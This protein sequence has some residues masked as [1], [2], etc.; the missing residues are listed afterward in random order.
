MSDK[1]GGHDDDREDTFLGGEMGGFSVEGH[2]FLDGFDKEKD[3]RSGFL[4]FGY[5]YPNHQYFELKLPHDDTQLGH[6]S[7]LGDS[8]EN[9]DPFLEL[10]E[11]LEAPTP[12]HVSQNGTYHPAVVS[13][14][15]EVGGVVVEK[16]EEENNKE[17]LVQ[18][19]PSPP[20]PPQEVHNHLRLSYTSDLK[21]RLRWTQDLHSCFVNAVKELGGPQISP[22]AIIEI[23]LRPVWCSNEKYRQGRRSVREFNEPLR[24]GISAAQGSE[25]PSS[26]MN[27]PPSQAKNSKHYTCLIDFVASTFGMLH[28]QLGLWL[29]AADQN[30]NQQATP[31]LVD[32]A[33]QTIHRYLHAQ[34]SYLSIAI[35]NACKFVSNQC[36]EGAALENGNYY[37]HGF[38]GSRS[39]NTALL[40]PYFY[41][42]QLNA[43]YACNSME[44]VNAGI[45]VEM[46]WSSFQ[47]PTT[48]QSGTENSSLPVGH[49]AGSCLEGSKT[50]PVQ[51]SEED[52]ASYEDPVD[53][54]LN[55]DDTC[56]NIL[57]IDYGRF[58][59]DGGVGTSK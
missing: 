39:G 6:L 58:D 35:N 57:A 50:L 43:S 56:T 42:N 40:M 38:T 32:F 9:D 36:V 14:N 3:G 46:P 26:S 53:D 17:G 29:S 22:D 31:M 33:Q 12:H 2:H 37:G 19:P 45:S 54:Y 48:V 59:L 24:N 20:R 27:L 11:T 4:E 34:G 49:S 41:Q 5:G 30:S 1:K 52:G 23:L 13:S 21:P 44:A 51:G 8:D 55:W 16:E 15:E 47:T 28:G 7:P 25:G 18:Q 10:Q